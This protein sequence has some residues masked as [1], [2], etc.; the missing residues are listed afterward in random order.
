MSLFPLHTNIS[1]ISPSTFETKNRPQRLSNLS[2]LCAR[3]RQQFSPLVNKPGVYSSICLEAVGFRYT[4]DS[5][6][7]RC[8]ECG[9]EE[10]NWALDVK[11]WTIHS[12]R[13][14]HC[15]FVCRLR[16]EAFSGAFSS[17]PRPTTTEQ[18]RSLPQ[19]PAIINLQSPLNTSVEAD[20]FQEAQ[21]RTFLDWPHRS[22]IPIEDMCK[23]GLFACN[24]GDRVI[25]IYCNSVFHKWT[26]YI[27][28]PFETHKVLSPQCPYVK[29]RLSSGQQ[30]GIINNIQ[31]ST[32]TTS[33]DRLRRNSTHSIQFSNL[34]RPPERNGGNSRSSR[35][36]T[37]TP[38]RSITEMIRQDS[39]Y[40]PIQNDE[41]CSKCQKSL[42]SIGPRQ[43][44]RADCAQWFM[45]CAHTKQYTAD[46]V[47]D[48]IQ[49]CKQ[50]Q[51]SPTVDTA[52]S[53]LQIPQQL[54]YRDF[55]LSILRQ[56]WRNEFHFKGKFNK[57][58]CFTCSN[59]L[60]MCLDNDSE[61]DVDLL[62]ACFIFQKQIDRI[63]G[64]PE[65]IEKPS[66]RMLEI[67]EQATRERAGMCSILLLVIYLILHYIRLCSKTS[68]CSSK[69]FNTIQPMCTLFY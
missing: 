25:C 6:V 16:D 39:I 50:K 20:S 56:I 12:T 10:S 57:L 33:N 61:A 1:T 67:R 14:P 19:K 40:Q 58:T 31:N 63:D 18:H 22:A 26:P 13:S 55:S 47:Y 23:A 5:D 29:E 38:S 7:A 69:Q 4:G 46:Q 9:L 45:H 32:N 48:Q 62:V 52:R 28:D 54:L 64:K 11:P 3:I 8:E 41:T 42:K 66:E 44:D 60:C 68:C 36:S 15:P 27:D 37:V 43:N 49:K 24:I 35:P 59:T 65:R 51:R 53:D 34:L 21:R 2:G 17:L 30:S